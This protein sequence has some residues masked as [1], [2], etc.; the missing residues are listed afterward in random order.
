MGGGGQIQNWIA[1]K[2]AAASAMFASASSLAIVSR[3][4]RISSPLLP[5]R[6]R[7]TARLLVMVR[8]YQCGLVGVFQ[9]APAPIVSGSDQ[10]VILPTGIEQK[11]GNLIHCLPMLIR[12]QDGSATLSGDLI[13]AHGTVGG[14]VVAHGSFA[15]VDLISIGCQDGSGSFGGQLCHWHMEQAEVLLNLREVDPCPIDKVGHLPEVIFVRGGQVAAGVFGHAS[16]TIGD[17][18][19][20]EVSPHG[21]RLN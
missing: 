17:A 4:C 13:D 21:V 7:E 10:Q 5:R 2:W 11:V 14:G 18:V 3:I 16:V 15:L 9:G 1:S 12:L 19:S 20:D 8:L 6:S